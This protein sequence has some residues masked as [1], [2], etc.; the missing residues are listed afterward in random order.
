MVFI[1]GAYAIR[2]YG[3]LFFVNFKTQKKSPG[4]GI[5]LYIPKK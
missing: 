2:P 3:I 4:W 1:L 5:F